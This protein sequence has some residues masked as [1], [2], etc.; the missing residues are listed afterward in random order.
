M[1]PPA[2]PP[3]R[4][5]RRLSLP[6]FDP[7]P[8]PHRWPA[9]SGTPRISLPGFSARFPVPTRRQPL[10][11]DPVSSERVTLRLEALGRALDD[12]PAQAQRLAR[13]RASRETA[14][15]QAT[16]PRHQSRRRFRR[17]SPLR[18][19]R[20]PGWREKPTHAVHDIL[21]VVHGLAFWALEPADTS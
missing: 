19:G 11:D 17:I 10:P 15:A 3:T 8:S 12:L 14:G 20:P 7:L 1:M 5:L 21:T 2:A 13:W 4:V 9:R 6:L 16:D 18:P